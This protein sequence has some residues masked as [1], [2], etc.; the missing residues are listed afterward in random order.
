MMTNNCN[1]PNCW[2][3]LF[4]PSIIT[5]STRYTDTLGETVSIVAYACS[6]VDV[7]F[8]RDGTLMLELIVAVSECV[9]HFARRCHYYVQVGSVG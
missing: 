9:R 6:F 2:S 4:S 8:I 7:S 5:N 1:G 3:T